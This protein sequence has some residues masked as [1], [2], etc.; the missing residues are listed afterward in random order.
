MKLIARLLVAV[1]FLVAGPALVAAQRAQCYQL[2][3]YLAELAG[4]WKEAP[5]FE[6]QMGKRLTETW[7]A[8]SES[9][10]SWT[11]FRVFRNGT[12]VAACPFADGKNFKPAASQPLPGDDS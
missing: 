9:T 8:V 5:A 7:L 12:Q 3:S 11:L 10:G 1:T 2:D 6:M 4:R